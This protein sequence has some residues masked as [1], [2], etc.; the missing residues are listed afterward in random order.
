VAQLTQ[1][2]SGLPTQQPEEEETAKRFDL[3]ILQLQLA[4]LEAAPRFFTLRDKIIDIA[5]NLE[6]KTG[7]PKVH[8]QLAFIQAV[9]TESYWAG[10][11]LPMLEALR[12][13]LRDLVQ[14]TDKS[15]RTVV[16]TD[17]QD[18]GGLIQREVGLPYMTAGV[19]VAQYRKK[20]EQFLRDHEDF[21]VIQK[22]RW[23]IP[24]ETPDLAALEDFFYR[25]EEVG[26]QEQFVQIYGRQENLAAFIRSLVGLDR[27]AAKARFAAFLD[28]QTFTADQIR[29]VNYIIDH[30]AANGTIDLN[31]LYDQPFTGIHDEGLDGIFADAQA[32]ALLAV[33]RAVNAVLE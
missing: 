23:A 27:K 5:A 18:E 31:L 28:G 19:N 6:T 32:E 4:H 3:L 22:I 8:A 12:Q 29:F 9:Q 20:V 17:F 33:V 24:L 13:R 14:H 1:Y 7:I 2:V 11:T 30:L 10:I 15:E 25:A 16:Y 26:G 21:W